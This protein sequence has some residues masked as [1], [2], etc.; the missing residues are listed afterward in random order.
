VLLEEGDD[1]L[2]N[3][4]RMFGNKFFEDLSQDEVERVLVQVNDKLRPFLFD[5]KQ[6]TADYRR[7][8]VV[9]QKKRV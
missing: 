2:S 9:G 5:G 3:W 4:L 1:G 8:R 7:I 6:W